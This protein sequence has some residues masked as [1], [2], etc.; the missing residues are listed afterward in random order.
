MLRIA[1]LALLF[2]A[3][4]LLIAAAAQADFGFQSGP[5]GFDARVQELPGA[6]PAQAGSHPYALELSLGFKSQAGFAEGDLRDLHLSL[7]PS[8][9]ANAAAIAKCNQADFHTPRTSPF[10]ESL[11]GESCPDAA[12]VG[13][14]AVKT[15][16]AGSL[17][18]SF[19][20]YNLSP[21]PGAPAALGASP[22]GSPIVFRLGLSQDGSLTLK[23]QG[24]AQS[25]DVQGFAITLWGT[26]AGSPTPLPGGE[27]VFLHDNERGNCLNEEDPA[28]HFGEP[29]RIVKVEQ[30]GTNPPKFD[31]IYKPGTCSVLLVEAP[32]SYLTLPTFCA[33]PLEFQASAD[34]WQDPKPAEASATALNSEGNPLTLGNCVEF[35]SAA[36]AQLQTDNAA[37]PSG[38][39]FNLAVNDGGGLLNETGRITSPIQ[40]AI[41]SLPEGVT[42][43]P[44]L[45]AG[46]GVCSPGDFARET[47]ATLP[48]Q[49][50]PNQAKIGTVAVE[51]LLGLPGTV[52]G[53]VYLAKPYDNPSGT[54][55]ALYVVARDP[56][57]GLFLKAGGKVVPDHRDGRLVVSFEDLPVLHYTHF[58]LNLREGQR[59]AL[60]SPPACGA[61]S[62]ALDLIPWSSPDV[63]LHDSSTL[64][65]NH[66]EAGGPCPSGALRPFAPH[67]EA[68][69]AN[70]QGGAYTPFFLHMTRTDAEQEITSYSATFPPGLLGKLAGIPY[71][72]EAAIEAAKAKSGVTERE[73]PSCPAASQIGRT[74]AGYG[75]GGVLAYAPGRLYLAGPYHGFPLSTVAVNSALVGPFDLGVVIVRSAIRVNP[76]S[77]QASID[78]AGSDPI[79]HILE[80]IPI[81]LRDIRVYV[82][83]PNFTLNPTSCD[84]LQSSS[85]LSGAGADVFSTADDVAATT[86]DRFQALNCPALGFAPKLSFNRKG[87]T[88]RGRFP[89]L[90]VNYTPKPGDAN[91]R[92]AAVSLPPSLFLA[93][94][95]ID[96]LCTRPQ[97]AAERCPPG[98]VYG[99]A[100]VTTPLLDAPMSGP[101]YL[102]AS[103]HLLPDIVFDLHGQGFRIEVPG[104]IDSDH[105]AIR[106]TFE[107]LPDAPVTKFTLKLIGGRRG[108]LVNTGRV[109]S[110]AQLAL[111]RFIGQNSKTELVRPKV[112]AHCSKAH[113]A[114]KGRT[115]KR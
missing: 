40:R 84:P 107:G 112:R 92:S 81:H 101:V 27:A 46:L 17:T 85:T 16:L 50:C 63:H 108:I 11:S 29:G 70:S 91:L 104:R 96:T 24:R 71:C 23:L 22:F 8:L 76:R 88:R 61:Y 32:P 97:F 31:F 57:R 115:A 77:A 21:P 53:S 111:A 10:Q 56:A 39:A 20:L 87:D 110:E 114:K 80:G 4:A 93:Q 33:T 109:C 86:N 55:V 94:E 51:G 47:L 41:V 74:L 99:H 13:V 49:G 1:S 65:I 2:C 38:L 26:P 30:P 78:S 89:S 60:I 52:E 106:A 83:R 103:D 35:R 5:A 98:S 59:A 90:R 44:S 95:H 82:D 37:S 3:G 113:R 7:P 36:K 66:G 54:L 102:R 45:G 42:I 100:S 73:A 79:P 75:V 43:N 15:G 25:Y 67:L 14:I 105:E 64:L 28:A 12:Q 68:G 69:S 58:T 19:G 6:P 18:R 34:S 9:L 48:G 72:S 62:A